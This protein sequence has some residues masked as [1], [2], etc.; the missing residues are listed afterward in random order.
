MSEQSMNESD[1]EYSLPVAREDL[2]KQVWEEPMLSLAKKYGVSSRDY[3]Q[4]AIQ[5]LVL[6]FQKTNRYM[7]LCLYFRSGQLGKLLVVLHSLLVVF[8]QVAPLPAYFWT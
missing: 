2:Y 4:E 6:H 8:P 7:R 1:L 5:L 3:L